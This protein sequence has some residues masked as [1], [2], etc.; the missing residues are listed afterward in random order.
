MRGKVFRRPAAGVLVAAVALLGAA[1]S[2]ADRQRDAETLRDSVPVTAGERISGVLLMSARVVE[3]P[4]GV[5]VG[6]D[7]AAKLPPLGF[8]AEPSKRVA[9]L[10]A[11]AGEPPMFL[12]TEESLYARRITANENERRPWLRVDLSRVND[13]DKPSAEELFGAGTGS[14]GWPAVVGPQLVIDMVAGVLTGSL[15]AG[16]PDADG[17][18]R[19]RFNVSI[20]KANREL[21]LHEDRREQRANMLRS[22]AITGDVF[23]GDATLR[24]DGSLARFRVLFH[25]MPNKQSTSELAA[26]LRL[27]K[28][29]PADAPGLVVPVKK[30]TIRVST[31]PALTAAVAQRLVLAFTPVPPVPAVQP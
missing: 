28:S 27:D 21:R 20:D 23:K 22:I 25:Q 14:L 16:K 18:R 8:V 7:T 26:E 1:C 11:K 6:S 4:E 9:S 12:S 29:T 13:S 17:S 2:Q 5:P 3:T 24:A 31:V 10:V 30:T 19:F 15:K